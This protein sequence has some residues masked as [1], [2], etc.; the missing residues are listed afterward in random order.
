MLFICLFLIPKYWNITIYTIIL[1]PPNPY[2]IL[3][4]QLHQYEEDDCPKVENVRICKDKLTS[5]EDDCIRPL[6][7][8]TDIK[9]CR[10][11]NVHIYRPIKQPVSHNYLLLIPTG[12]PLKVKKTCIATGYSIIQEPSLLKIPHHCEIECE[13]FRYKNEEN[14][15]SAEPFLLPKIEVPEVVE[16]HTT[17]RIIL[18]HPDLDE[19]SKLKKKAAELSPPIITQNRE[20]HF[21]YTF[22]IIILLLA[23]CTWL[24]AKHRGR[25]RAICRKTAFA[26]DDNT[27][28]DPN[29][30]SAKKEG[31][32]QNN[33]S[34]LFSDLAREEL[35]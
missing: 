31:T 19:I 30:S 22:V 12:S 7:H 28:P 6:I 34:V 8:N 35:Y 27:S 11:A 1:V 29:L 33:T 25:L 14:S 32:S 24:L 2:L 23:P 10:L 16:Q 26:S 9:N 17:R 13:G 15:I 21:T 4:S 18:H 3:G 5:N 20:V